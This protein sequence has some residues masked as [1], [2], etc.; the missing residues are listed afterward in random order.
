V[1][2]NGDKL[3]YKMEA[4][5]RA[6]QLPDILDTAADLSPFNPIIYSYGVIMRWTVVKT[7]SMSDGERRVINSL[8]AVNNVLSAITTA[9]LIA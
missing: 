4:R 5:V 1:K 6:K 9:P 3:F 8:G 2:L 7:P